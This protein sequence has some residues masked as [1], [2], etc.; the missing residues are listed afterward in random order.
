MKLRAQNSNSTDTIFVCFWHN[1]AMFNAYKLRYFI[2]S[3]SK[4][5][6]TE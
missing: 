3:V 2:V 1:K 5:K 4:E 6:N